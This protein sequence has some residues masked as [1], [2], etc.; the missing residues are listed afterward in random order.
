MATDKI[1][2]DMAGYHDEEEGV[3][4]D[5]KTGFRH[6]LHKMNPVSPR[7]KGDL[8]IIKSYFK[9]DDH[10]RIDMRDTDKHPEILKVAEVR[11]GLELCDEEIA[12]MAK[13]K[14]RMKHHFA[15]YLGLDPDSIDPED[16][17]TIALGGSGGGYRAM[18][19]FLSYSTEMKRCGLWDLSMYISGV[20]GSCWSI[21]SYYTFGDLNFD[22]VI[23]HCKRRFSPHHPLSDDA[24]R[25]VLSAPKGMDLLLGPLEIKSESGLHVVPMDYYSVLT[26]G[27]IFLHDK[28]QRPSNTTEP[29]FSGFN[30]E[31]FKFTNIKRHVADGAEP[32][33]I[34]TAIRH[35]R[36]WKDWTDKEHPFK[37]D[38]VDEKEHSESDAWWQWFEMTPFE[39]GCDELESWVPT[40][41]FGRQFEGGRSKQ[42]LP[43]HSLALLLGL[44]V[45]APAGSMSS[46]LATIKRNLPGNFLGSQIHDLAKGISRL[47]GAHG[48][49]V[50]ESHHP[51]HACNEHNFLFH[52]TENRPP[53]IQNSPRIHM[54]DSGMDNNCPT[55]VLLHPSRNVDIL[56]T[57]DASSDVEKDQQGR[58]D[59][60]GSRKGIKFTRRQPDATPY[61]QVFDGKLCDRPEIVVDSYG[62][63]FP[64][65]PAPIVRQESSI[66]YMPLLKNEE[67]VPDF[68]PA[69]SE[70]FE[71]LQSYL[72]PRSN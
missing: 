49:A 2:I 47:W 8:R 62:K 44:T 27:H 15:Q 1:N 51:L 7:A 35:E 13:R 52:L 33:P 34:L 54:I 14:A 26:T 69:N 23:E 4:Q 63:T 61:A 18:L 70:V 32:L 57:V 17:P 53:G 65:P 12:F 25:A 39:I 28:E 71:F 22:K 45:S 67:A 29:E 3:E 41:G 68:N 50:F 10:A 38:K 31:W 30:P 66:V 36:P 43:E 6:F 46:Y 60:I 59:Q 40:W 20:S 9:T 5:A 58:I 55:Y 48:T 24:I 19:G 56:L 42:G 11:T 21:A 72:D 16:I 64:T 37:T